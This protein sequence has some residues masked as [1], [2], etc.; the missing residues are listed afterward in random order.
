MNTTALALAIALAGGFAAA[1]PLD[2][3][4]PAPASITVNHLIAAQGTVAP[5]GLGHG[6][7]DIMCKWVSWC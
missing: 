6:I 3:S 7:R 5:S 2:E 4:S 1:A